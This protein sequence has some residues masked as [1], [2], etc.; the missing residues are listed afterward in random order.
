MSLRFR[1]VTTPTRL[2]LSCISNGLRRFY[3][4][5]QCEEVGQQKI[6]QAL[7]SCGELFSSRLRSMERFIA[8]QAQIV[9]PLLEGRRNPMCSGQLVDAPFKLPGFN[10]WRE[11]FQRDL[12]ASAEH[13]CSRSPF[14]SLQAVECLGISFGR[15]SRGRFGRCNG[16]SGGFDEG[17]LQRLIVCD[18]PTEI[19]Q[20]HSGRIGQL[21]QYRR[22][23][24]WARKHGVYKPVSRSRRIATSKHKCR[25]GGRAA[26]AIVGEDQH[27]LP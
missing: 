2:W 11:L 15:L 21:N 27:G 24:S 22:V 9:C 8:V 5:G 17:D 1:S 19:V 26:R 4:C 12:K 14:A 13:R 10:I 20:I 3:L 18:I 7:H 23:A 25:R 16:F 6:G